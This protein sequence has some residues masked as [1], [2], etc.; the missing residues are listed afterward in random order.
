MPRHWPTITTTAQGAVLHYCVTLKSLK[1]TI[2]RVKDKG[3]L[4]P[5]F[6][7]PILP[8]LIENILGD[9]INS[10]NIAHI[11]IEATK[12]FREEK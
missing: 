6:T 4:A 10:N 1:A 2:R 8:W 11:K 3:P 12:L 9:S 7:R 5:G